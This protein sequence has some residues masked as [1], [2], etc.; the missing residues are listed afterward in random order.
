MKK[1]I[2]VIIGILIFLGLTFFYF[3][4]IY[5]WLEFRRNTDTPDKYINRTI[6]PTENY[7]RDESALILQFND[8]KLNHKGFFSSKEYFE[9]TEIIIDTIL[10]S[11]EYDKLVVLMIA[12][13]PTSRQLR[14]QKSELWYYDATSY[15]GLRQNDSIFLSQVGS[16]FSNSND[17]LALSD[18]LRQA[19]FRTF[20]SKD[21]TAINSHKYNLNDIRFWKSP[22]W[23]EI[24]IDQN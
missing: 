20:V 2:F 21:T 4:N 24:E 23:E 8:M 13:N 6:I 18:I 10:Y 7:Q 3:K 17:L 5:G 19:S 15:L 1:R 11:P 16:N 22:E 9:G 12:K 14:P